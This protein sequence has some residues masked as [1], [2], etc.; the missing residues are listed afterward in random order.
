MPTL[1]SENE[2]QYLFTTPVTLR[3]V[4]NAGVQ[5]EDEFGYNAQ[6]HQDLLDNSDILRIVFGLTW[7]DCDPLEWRDSYN[8]E[9][10]Q[11]EL[12]EDDAEWSPCLKVYNSNIAGYK[13][14][15]LAVYNMSILITLLHRLVP[16]SDSTWELINNKRAAGE[17]FARGYYAQYEEVY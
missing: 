15:M 4:E 8:L 10:Y 13:D 11:Q 3:Q 7:S 16:F 6:E 5:Y 2:Y 14:R 17:A 1:L 12:G 9:S